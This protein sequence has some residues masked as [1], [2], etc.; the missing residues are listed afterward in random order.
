MAKTFDIYSMKSKKALPEE[1]S[2]WKAEPSPEKLSALLYS[3][4]PTINSALTSFASGDKSLATRAYI[5]ARQSLDTFDPSKGANL[6]THVFNDLKR[7][8]RFYTERSQT[9]HIPEN[10]KVDNAHIY[11]FKLD[12]EDKHDREPSLTE[13]TDGTGLSLK[14]VQKAASSTGEVAESMFTTETGDSLDKSKSKTAES[15]WSDYVYHDLDE[16]GKKI[17]EWT[18]GYNGVKTIPKK[19]MAT[20]LKMSPAAISS[21]LNTIEKRLNEINE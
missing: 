17:F 14:R 13:I 19:D 5:L 16:K 15:I 2:A 9:V 21:R 3:L 11:R 20:K 4:R 12:F 10:V 18:T 1:Y 6:K 8:N 7:L